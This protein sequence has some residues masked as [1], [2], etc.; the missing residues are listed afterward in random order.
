MR[1]DLPKRIQTL[2]PPPKRWYQ[3]EYVKEAIEIVVLFVAFMVSM[4][5]I[6]AFFG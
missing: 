5:L 1:H 6:Q 2:S 3:N 4:L